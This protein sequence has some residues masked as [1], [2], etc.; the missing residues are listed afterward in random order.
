VIYNSATRLYVL[1]FHLDNSDYS[2]RQV[3]VATS[4]TP[5][6]GMRGER[7]K[8]GI[9]K[10]EGDREERGERRE[11]ERERGTDRQT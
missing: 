8:R 11:G 9:E 1:W 10:G 7:G 2:L 3:G 4:P 6:G 5:N